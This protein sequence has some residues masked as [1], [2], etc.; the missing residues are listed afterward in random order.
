MD[1]RDVFA[2]PQLRKRAPFALRGQQVLFLASIAIF[3]VTLTSWLVLYLYS[4]R[5]Y[6]VNVDLRSQIASLSEDLDPGLI[7]ELV[8]LSEQLSSARNIIKNHL[9][10]SGVF[11]FL[12]KN[13]HPK[14]AYSSISYSSDSK[15]MYLAA[16]AASYVVLARQISIFEASPVVSKVFFGGLKIEKD[17]G[18]GFSLN[19]EFKPEL[20]RVR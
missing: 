20:I 11:E 9:L 17:G 13:T 18:V 14:V 3:L 16:R 19:I 2:R 15:T 1:Q 6:G 7:K 5:L 8:I 12:E 10:T 4:G